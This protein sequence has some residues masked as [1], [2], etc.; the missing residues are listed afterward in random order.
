MLKTLYYEDN[1][2]K[3]DVLDKLILLLYGGYFILTP[4][5]LWSSGIPQLADF[6]LVFTLILFFFKT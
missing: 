2:K 1:T 5:Y 4:F 6:I 3:I